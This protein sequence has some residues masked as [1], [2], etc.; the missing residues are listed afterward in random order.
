MFVMNYTFVE[1][2]HISILANTSKNIR[3]TLQLFGQEEQDKPYFVSEGAGLVMHPEEGFRADFYIYAI[4]IAGTARL[5][6]NNQ[7]VHIKTNHFFA[8]IPSSVIQVL[9][10]SKNFKAKVLVFEKSFLLKNILD[11]RQLE[12]LGF[13]SFDT[14]AH[15]D[16]N[17]EEFLL[18]KNKLDNIYEKTK[19]E[20]LFQDQIVQSLIFNLLFETASIF[21]TY[22]QVVRKKALS[23]ED[24]LFM[25]FMKLVQ[26]NFKTQQELSFYADKLFISPKY[27]IQLCKNISGKTPGNILSETLVNEARLLLKMPDNNISTVSTSLN[28]GS[29]AA[30]SKFFKKHTGISPSAFRQQ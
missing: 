11:A 2:K 10:H 9:E 26:F 8:A 20:S 1:H 17:N 22:R 6:L 15:I 12:H 29:V 25:K 7:E 24:E 28:Y 19:A 27:L 16:L 30:F 4:C 3:T 21:F 23:R 14:L 18:L 5:S 13:F